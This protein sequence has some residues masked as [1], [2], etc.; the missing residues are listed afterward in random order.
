MKGE[1][2]ESLAEIRQILG[3]ILWVCK[4]KSPKEY[5]GVPQAQ[6]EKNQ[7]SDNFALQRFSYLWNLIIFPP[8]EPIALDPRVIWTQMM[9]QNDQGVFTW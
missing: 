1:I 5:L 2:V 4:H 9:Y 7:K 8:W 3:Y 6:S